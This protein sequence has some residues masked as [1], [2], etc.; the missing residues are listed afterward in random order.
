M[1]QPYTGT[2]ANSHRSTNYQ[3]PYISQSHGSYCCLGQGKDERIKHSFWR[4]K[5]KA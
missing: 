3:G 5:S 2:L 1:L 4:T